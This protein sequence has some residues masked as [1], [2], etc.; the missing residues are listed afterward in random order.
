MEKDQ[1]I[2]NS[3]KMNISKSYIDE[4]KIID[5]QFPICI[6]SFPRSGNTMMRGIIENSFNIFTGD[7]MIIPKNHESDESIL[8][9]LGIGKSNNLKR[10]FFIKTHY[11]NFVFKK[12]EFLTQGAILM[13][14]NPFDAFDSYF[15]LISNESHDKKYSEIDRKSKDIMDKFDEFIIWVTQQYQVFHNY[16]ISH[17]NVIPI[18]IFKY[19]EN[20]DNKEKLTENVINFI[21]KFS[22]DKNYLGGY[23]LEEI[24]KRIES[25]KD[26]IIHSFT[27]KIGSE[28]K[29]YTSLQR[30]LFTQKQIDSIISANYDSLLF[31]NY[32]DDFKSL[33]NEKI[34]LAISKKESEMKNLNLKPKCWGFEFKDNDKMNEKLF[35]NMSKNFAERATLRINDKEN[36]EYI[37]NYI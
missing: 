24:F 22:P 5:K 20:T 31:F 11:P 36:D 21:F 29:H 3:E 33:G 15:E 2:N 4:S 17:L 19:E 12:N 9:A 27:Y 25:D 10:T 28:C 23:T 13:V 7:D 30:D 35:E 6:C 8:E 34:N 14:R 32:I 26:S 37:H 16:W 18:K 1:K